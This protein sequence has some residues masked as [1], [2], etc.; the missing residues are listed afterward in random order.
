[1]MDISL[2]LSHNLEG[3]ANVVSQIPSIWY[4]ILKLILRY[5]LI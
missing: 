4:V 5:I 1:M 3:R 2:E